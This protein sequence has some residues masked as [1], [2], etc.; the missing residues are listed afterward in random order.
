MEPLKLTCTSKV[1]ANS[2][3][4]E[5]EKQDEL[6]CAVTRAVTILLNISGADKHPQLKGSIS[7]LSR[8]KVVRVDSLNSPSAMIR[9]I[10]V[11]AVKFNISDQAQYIDQLLR[12]AR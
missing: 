1:K 5:Y 4:Q 2:D 9:T 3:K 11:T 10:V 12:A 7:V 8:K 6:K